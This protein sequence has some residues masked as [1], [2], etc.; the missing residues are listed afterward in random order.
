MKHKSNFQPE[1]NHETLCLR[2]IKHKDMHLY[3]T[4][5]I[6]EC[7]SMPHM[8]KL[9]AISVHAVTQVV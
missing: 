6:W 2:A 1:W 8:L 7:L 3:T 9:R 4:Q 5:F